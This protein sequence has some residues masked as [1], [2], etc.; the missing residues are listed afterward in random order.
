SH[1][2]PLKVA[3]QFRVLEALA[4]G[5]IDL[6]IGRSP[7]G[8]A[9]AAE[10]LGRQGEGTFD[11][12]VASLIALLAD[13]GE[14]DRPLRAYPVVATMAEP[15]ILSSSPRGAALAAS[16]GLPYCFNASHDLNH[17]LLDEA[18]AR[19]REDFRPGALAARPRLALSVFALAAEEEDRALFL[20][21]PR[22]HWRVGLDRGRRSGMISPEAAA[23]EPYSPAERSRI[24]QSLTYSFVGAGADVARRLLALAR[25]TGAEELVL[26][27]WCH[28]MA[29][30]ERSCALIAAEMERLQND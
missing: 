5:R 8:S 23:A 27:T 10:A 28:A 16:L 30:R 15:W 1:Y 9:A 11:A 14:D 2:A 19:Y 29:D 17:G 22:G 24:A 7:G 6:G 21:G 13:K 20:Y 12:D 18:V 26:T 3:A 25:R 4:P